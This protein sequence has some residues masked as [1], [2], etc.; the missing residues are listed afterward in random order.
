LEETTTSTG[1]SDNQLHRAILLVTIIVLVLSCPVLI[2]EGS[3]LEQYTTVEGQPLAYPPRYSLPLPDI[4]YYSN[5]TL[6]PGTAVEKRVEISYDTV[7]NHT[8]FFTDAN[9]DL[10]IQTPRPEYDLSYG[11]EQYVFFGFL[12]LQNTGSINW[13]LYGP[14]NNLIDKE[15]IDNSSIYSLYYLLEGYG[16]GTYLLT[17]SDV[18]QSNFLLTVS[19]GYSE[20]SWSKPYFFS[21]VLGIALGIVGTASLPVLGICYA[22]KT[23]FRET[24]GEDQASKGGNN[25]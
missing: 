14:E 16:N 4:A 17:V 20:T 5:V 18:G 1:E 12:F 24:R 2:V 23:R 7:Y 15:S 13:T 8:V 9:S 11:Q 25:Y 22:K 3:N 10:L 21:G 6:S 19:L